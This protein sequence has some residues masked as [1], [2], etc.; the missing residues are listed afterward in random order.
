MNC[1]V[2][3]NADGA[4]L[5]FMLCNPDLGQPSGDCLFLTVPGQV[6][7]FARQLPGCCSSVGNWARVRG[8]YPAARQ[9]P[10]SSR[11]PACPPSCLSSLAG[12]APGGGGW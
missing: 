1:V 5:G 3:Q 12:R 8:G 11:R 9:C 4:H 10:S 7:L 6:E 2:L